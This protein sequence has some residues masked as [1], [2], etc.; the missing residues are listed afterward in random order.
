MEVIILGVAE[1][2]SWEGMT[3]LNF[4]A[5]LFFEFSDRKITDENK[6]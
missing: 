6:I 4:R 1:S 3:F 5:F 2:G